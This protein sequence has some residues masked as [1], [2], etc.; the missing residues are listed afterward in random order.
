MTVWV[1]GAKGMLGRHVGEQLD[2]KS[3]PWVATDLELDIGNE[4]H[5]KE[6]FEA[7]RPTIVINCAAYTAVDAAESDRATAERV[8]ALGPEILAKA[9]RASDSSLVHFSTDYVFGGVGT[10]PFTEDDVIAP[11]NVYGATKAE[12]ERRITGAMTGDDADHDG[13]WWILR[14]S[15][16]FGAGRSSFVETMWRLM[17]E[18]SEL[19]VVADQVG[20]PT[21]ADDLARAALTV[22]GVGGDRSPF[23]NGVW[24]FANTGDT[25]WYDFA[26]AI[27]QVMLDL[28]ETVTVE[29]ITPVTTAEFPR[30][31]SRPKYSVLSTKRF[32][33]VAGV[34]PR[35][36]REALVEFLRQRAYDKLR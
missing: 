11:C 2:A 1:T 34:A 20:R 15:W 31:A 12:G 32:E 16:L 10:E 21:Y 7:N 8:N 27:R 4:A 3:V 5:V 19:R 26:R 17:K 25:S 9:C 33:Q 23:S 29:R 14:T 13:H 35:S 30:P 36:W 24:H 6:F 28:G 18:K 22:A